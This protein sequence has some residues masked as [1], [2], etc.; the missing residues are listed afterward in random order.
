MFLI[1]TVSIIIPIKYNQK[2]I[3]ASNC[4]IIPQCLL[5]NHGTMITTLLATLATAATAAPHKLSHGRLTV[6]E[7]RCLKA[8]DINIG[9]GGTSDPYCVVR[10]GMERR[11]TATIRRELNPKWKKAFDSGT[12]L[13][14]FTIFLLA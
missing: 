5:S 14:G 1:G 9:R 6:V 4:T 2:T 12:Q 8:M 13:K 10:V 3:F 7:A 11:E